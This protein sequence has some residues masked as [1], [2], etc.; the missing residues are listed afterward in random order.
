MIGELLDVDAEV[1]LPDD[2]DPD[3]TGDEIVARYRALWD[4]LTRDET[5]APT[6]GTSWTS[7]CTGSTSSGSTSRRS[8]SRR[9]TAATGCGSTR[10]SSSRAI[11]VTAC[12]A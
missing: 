9:P 5:F 7:A 2:L 4:E 3:E 12:C 10:T 11:T 6:S 8:S 1:G